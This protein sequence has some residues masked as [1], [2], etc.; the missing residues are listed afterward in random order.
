MSDFWKYHREGSGFM[1]QYVIDGTP[2]GRYEAIYY[3]MESRHMNS[4]SAHHYI[5]NLHHV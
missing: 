1:I 3:L 5:E 2:M 4:E